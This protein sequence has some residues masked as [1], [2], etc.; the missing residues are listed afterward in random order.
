[1][2]VIILAAG[3]GRR[4]L[5]HTA[6]K[7][8]AL[9]DI[10][11][12]TL[13]ERQVQAFAECGIT[14]FVVVTGYGS[15]QMEQA[16]AT[17]GTRYRVQIR[18]VFNPFFEVADNLASCWMAR[19]EMNTDFIQVNGDNVFRADVVSQLL[20]APRVSASVAV[21]RKASYD[22]DDM[23]VLF[24]GDFVQDIGKSLDREK[25]EAEAIGFYLFRDE[26]P[27]RYVDMLERFMRNPTALKQWFPSAVAAL[28]RE[29]EV[30]TVDITGVR[31]AE[32]DFPQDYAQAVALVQEWEGEVE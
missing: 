2:R 25:V 15:Q 10:G 28:A 6:S 26:G 5:P 9:L 3:Q 4:L 22:D 1:M 17:V 27:A 16:L 21:N 29:M 19:G 8:K 20:A 7:P 30:R 13:V 12:K 32:V 14:D 31:W 24:R 23:K 11:G 18:T